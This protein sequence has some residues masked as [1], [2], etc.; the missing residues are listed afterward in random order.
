MDAWLETQGME[1]ED[2]DRLLRDEARVRRVRTLAELDLERDLLDH[3]RL[4]GHYGPLAERAR[5]K[6]RVLAAHG[7]DTPSLNDVGLEER[8]LWRWYFEE[9]LAVPAPD[10]V[11]AY[12]QTLDF[13]DEGALRRALLR[14]LCYLRLCAHA[15]D[16]GRPA[17]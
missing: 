8:D 15:H 16:A 1:P 2:F 6:Q 9:V 3:L 13:E 7:M 11:S 17:P 10:N 4:A 5:D 12:A 14:E